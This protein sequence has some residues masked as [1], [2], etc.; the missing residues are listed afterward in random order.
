M[1]KRLGEDVVIVR[2]SQKHRTDALTNL[3][4]NIIM[5]CSWKAAEKNN[6][7]NYSLAR[8]NL[9]MKE[10]P[11]TAANDYTGQQLVLFSEIIETTGGTSP[12]ERVTILHHATC[13]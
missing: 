10:I 13:V 12:K 6:H 1:L 3:R 2:N 8:E 4:Q 7:T 11:R 5:S 9:N